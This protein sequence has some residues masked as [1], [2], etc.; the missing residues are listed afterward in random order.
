M[1]DSI[2]NYLFGMS[3]A[4]KSVLCGLLGHYAVEVI[5]FM[6]FLKRRSRCRL[7]GSF[8]PDEKN[9]NIGPSPGDCWCK[10]SAFAQFHWY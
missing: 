9:E 2:L 7:L 5:Y 3:Q 4:L 1:V 10:V 6:M 8:S